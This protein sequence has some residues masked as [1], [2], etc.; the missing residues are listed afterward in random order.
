MLVVKLLE[1][2][3]G[4]PKGYAALRLNDLHTEE[5]SLR[6]LCFYADPPEVN[7]VPEIPVDQIALILASAYG[8]IGSNTC[9]RPWQ[10]CKPRISTIRTYGSCRILSPTK[11]RSSTLAL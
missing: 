2:E 4:G 6:A 9:S 1:R 11:S 10:H 8:H 7:A 3:I 5:G